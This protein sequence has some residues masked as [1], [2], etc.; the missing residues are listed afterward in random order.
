MFPDMESVTGSEIVS[1]R[2]EV[3]GALGTGIYLIAIVMTVLFKFQS[4]R[5]L[6]LNELGDF[7]AGAFGPVAFL[8]LVLGFLQQGRELKLS[9]D[10]LRLQVEELRNSVEQQKRLA[11]A[12]MQQ[13]QSA[14]QALELQLQ[15]AERAVTADFEVR[16]GVKYMQNLNVINQI[17]I[18]NN[19]NVA[20]S[21]SSVFNGDLK[22]YGTAQ[23][24]TIKAGQEVSMELV[25]DP[26]T[27]SKSGEL[28]IFYEDATGV[29]RI[30]VF[31]F[32]IVIDNW[33]RFEK[34]RYK[35]GRVI[36]S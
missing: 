16:S 34:V 35:S 27:E 20:Y 31:S 29:L 32:T 28:E 1:R 14:G 6:E 12:T 2:L 11:D 22:F 21:V 23:H 8:W 7:L 19:R 18:T 13:I 24:G 30:E 9:T 33:I 36:R 26:A 15:G 17:K 3:W 4:F 5:E 10:A 25:F